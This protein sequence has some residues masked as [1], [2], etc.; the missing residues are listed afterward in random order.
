MQV[1]SDNFK[2]NINTQNGIKQTN[3]MT[4]IVAQT[5]SRL[6]QQLLTPDILRLKQEALKIIRLKKTRSIFLKV[7]KI[8]LCLKNFELPV[9]F[10]LKY[11]V[12]KSFFTREQW[13]KI[14]NSSN[15]LVEAMKLLIKTDIML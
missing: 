12:K 2:T 8:L 6:L 10:Q 11:Y 7:W 5:Q 13:K 14:Y 3:E 15:L 1:K 9:S 4:T